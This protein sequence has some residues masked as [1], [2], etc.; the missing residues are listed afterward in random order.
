MM[1]PMLLLRLLTLILLQLPS[2]MEELKPF[3]RKIVIILMSNYIVLNIDRGVKRWYQYI[4][5]EMI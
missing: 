5:T 2:V 4:A 3:Q 1:F